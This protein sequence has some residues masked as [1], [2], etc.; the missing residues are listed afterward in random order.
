MTIEKNVHLDLQEGI[1]TE[2]TFVQLLTLYKISFPINRAI[3]KF[4]FCTVHVV[5]I[6]IFEAESNS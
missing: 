4:L 1:S 2:K 6:T 3:F 5:F